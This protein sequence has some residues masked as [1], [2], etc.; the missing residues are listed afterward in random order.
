MLKL[1]RIVPSPGA[2]LI[3]SVEVI[4]QLWLCI[5]LAWSK[6][7]QPFTG[8]SQFCA[9]WMKPTDSRMK[10]FCVKRLNNFSKITDFILQKNLVKKFRS[11]GKRPYC[12]KNDW[13][14]HFSPATLFSVD[15]MSKKHTRRLYEVSLLQTSL[16]CSSKESNQMR[17]WS[18]WLLNLLKIILKSNINWNWRTWT[19][20][21]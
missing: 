10:N 4:L 11:A 14:F 8:Q 12:Y 15:K 6:V 3:S 1:L 9:I 7:T 2:V 18:G 20:W 17:L 13:L 19:E 5:V 21:T 16:T